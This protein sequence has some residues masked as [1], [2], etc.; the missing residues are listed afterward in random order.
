MSPLTSLRLH[1]ELEI[2]ATAHSSPPTRLQAQLMESDAS[3]VMVFVLVNV[4]KSPHQQRATIAV[5]RPIRQEE[6]DWDPECNLLHHL[7][8]TTSSRPAQESGNP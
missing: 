8:W 5:F 1:D 2:A 7:A 3:G 4:K 6:V